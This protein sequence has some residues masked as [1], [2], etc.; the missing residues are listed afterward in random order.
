MKRP[1]REAVS[2]QFRQ[3]RHSSDRPRPNRPRTADLKDAFRI[4]PSRFRRLLFRHPK[5]LGQVRLALSRLPPKRF[6]TTAQ[7]F[8]ALLGNESPKLLD[9]GRAHFL[10]NQHG[11][12]N[13]K[14]KPTTT[15]GLAEA[16]RIKCAITSP[17]SRPD[18]RRTSRPPRASATQILVLAAAP[19]FAPDQSIAMTRFM[20]CRTPLVWPYP[21]LLPLRPAHMLGANVFW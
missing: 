4:R 1:D 21:R 6:R 9:R 17:R 18:S 5:V 13:A 8:L 11:K 20:A 10:A 16:S 12:E 19:D 14:S 2:T 7:P 3:V 15:S